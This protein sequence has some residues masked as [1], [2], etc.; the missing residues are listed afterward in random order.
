MNIFEEAAHLEKQNVPFALVTIV[1]SKG[2]TPRSQARMIVLGDGTTR[3]TIGGGASEYQAIQRALE[4]IPQRKSEVM[5]I[6]LAVSDG[7]WCGGEVDVFIEVVVPA[8]RLILIGGGH[9][10]LQI[11]RLASSCGWYVELVETRADFATEERFPSVSA[12]HIGPTLD[13][14]L[15]DLAIDTQSA[16]VIATHDLDREALQRL[17]C[18]SARYVGMLGSRTKVN[19]FKRYLVNEKRIDTKLLS[20][21]YSPI[22]LDI[23]SETPEQIAV[24][25]LAELM[26]VF[27]K[28]SAQPLSRKANHLVVVRGAGD[29]ATGVICRLYRAGYQVLALETE[30]PTTIRRTVA[31]SEAM[32]NTTATVEGVVCRKA[33]HEQEIKTILDQKEVAL[34]CDPEGK[35][36]ASLHPA[37]VVDAIIAKKN[38]GTALDM[39]PLVIALGPGF[40]AQQDCHIVVETQRGHDLGRI[41]TEGQAAQDTGVPGMIGGYGKERVLHAPAFGTFKATSTIGDMVQ[42]GQ[43]IAF[44]GEVPVKATIDG[45]LRGLLHDG[46]QVPEGFKIADIDPRGNPSYCFTISDK[47]RAIGGAVLEAV[48][49]YFS[50]YM[51]IF[52]DLSR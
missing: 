33:E 6:S 48:D 22:G 16:I 50:G 47:A 11:A 8:N 5:H 21:L 29:L 45:V 46:L 12:F 17:I 3:G 37:V 20:R 30:H 24:S 36:I 32:Y 40:T 14:A 9:V 19:E 26:M 42:A 51:R 23:G 28:G 43:V 35:S 27:N 7:H 25:V 10:N 52:D 31:F 41:I 49:G 34:F 38:L 2:S 1:S 4:L 39:A 44:V 15:S 13:E 18:S